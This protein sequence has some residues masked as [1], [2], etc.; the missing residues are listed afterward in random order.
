M[1]WDFA[2]WRIENV[3]SMICSSRKVLP[4]PLAAHEEN[5]IFQQRHGAAG[6]FNPVGPRQ[7]RQL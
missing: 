5:Q 4:M 6:V 1:R 7:A 3:Y 2:W